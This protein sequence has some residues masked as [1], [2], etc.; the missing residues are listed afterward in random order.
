MASKRITAAEWDARYAG[1]FCSDYRPEPYAQMVADSQAFTAAENARIDALCAADGAT[2]Y[3]KKILGQSQ[4][5]FVS[6]LL[7]KMTAPRSMVALPANSESD[8]AVR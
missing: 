6:A 3:L 7:D 5:A 4:D 1:T 2:G 8:A